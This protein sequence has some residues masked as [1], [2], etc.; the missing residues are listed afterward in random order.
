MWVIVFWDSLIIDVR[1][2]SPPLFHSGWFRLFLF[3]LSPSLFAGRSSAVKKSNSAIKTPGWFGMF[4]EFG[5]FSSWGRI[6]GKKNLE[7]N[8]FTEVSGYYLVPNFTIINE[9]WVCLFKGKPIFLRDFL[10]NIIW[11][12]K[13]LFFVAFLDNLVIFRNMAWNFARDLRGTI[14]ILYGL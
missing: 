9:N 3:V 7:D 2:V 5:V 14:T 11:P 4:N 1:G 13:M 8:I 10:D 6:V 12:N